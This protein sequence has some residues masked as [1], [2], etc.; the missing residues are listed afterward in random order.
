MD[1]IAELVAEALGQ[2]RLVRKC[3]DEKIIALLDPSQRSFA[4]EISKCIAAGTI[5][6]E[7]FLRDL[8]SFTVFL[9]R[10]ARD[11]TTYEWC[12][13][14]HDPDCGYRLPVP[15]Q[16]ADAFYVV[17]HELVDLASGIGGALD[18]ARAYA[19]TNELFDT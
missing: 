16:R 15:S 9:D 5:I 14:E 11:E 17:L 6:S 4:I 10:L 2:A 1:T 12:G 7:A 19:I 8:E 13:H 3:L 18:A